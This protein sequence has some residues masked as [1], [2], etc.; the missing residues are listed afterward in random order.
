MYT[1]EIYDRTGTTLLSILETYAGMQI[2]WKL[3][4]VSRLSFSIAQWDEWA[5]PVIMQ[6]KN[7][8]ILKK[9]NEVFW[10]WIINACKP[11][12]SRIDVDCSDMLDLLRWRLFDIISTWNLGTIITNI[13]TTSNSQWN[14]YI[15]NL[16]ITTSKTWSFDFTMKESLEAIKE[17]CNNGLEF[18]LFSNTL[19]VKDDVWTLQDKILQ[20][21]EFYPI[22]NNI[23][24]P[25]IDEDWKEIWNSIT[26][27]W[28]WLLMSNK[29][30]TD[31]INKYWI[32]K[33]YVVYS[34]AYN[35]ATL[36]Q[37][38]QEYLDQNKEQNISVKFDLIVKEA[39]DWDNYMI[40]DYVRAKVKKWYNN[41]EK[42]MKIVWITY[43][44]KNKSSIPWINF[45]L[46][47]NKKWNKSFFEDVIDMKKRI[48]SLEKKSI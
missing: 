2:T 41:I 23:N 7:Q 39:N 18:Y 11:W 25:D 34:S 36:D 20:Y 29:Y 4:E 47:D 44:I 30:D 45:E 16:D 3:N 42:I 1:I 19:V 26:W 33:K 38:T 43:N 48:V 21:D 24:N 6:K 32:H 10:K 37:M 28:D 9:N 46:S 12:N 17:V 13:I 31:S 27:R 5:T 15:P 22:W 40:W 14:I 8:V 35:Q